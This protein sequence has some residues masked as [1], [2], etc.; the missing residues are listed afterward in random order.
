LGNC[1]LKHRVSYNLMLQALPV[2]G[3]KPVV[4]EFDA[5]SGRWLGG[6]AVVGCGGF[7]R[8]R[9]EI[10]FGTGVRSIG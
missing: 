6:G 9:C 1:T 8:L 7:G 4:R 10:G 3:S 2:G 5:D